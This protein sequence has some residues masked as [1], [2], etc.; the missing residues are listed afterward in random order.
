MVV[1]VY[2]VMFVVVEVGCLLC[3]I[4]VSFVGLLVFE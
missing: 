1:L 2:E 3:F 4:G